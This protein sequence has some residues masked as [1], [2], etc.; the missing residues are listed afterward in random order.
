MFPL[1]VIGYNNNYAKGEKGDKKGELRKTTGTPARTNLNIN[2]ISTPFVNNGDSD[3]DASGNSGFEYPLGSGKTAFF[4][5]GLIWGC[6]LDGVTS[7]DSIRVGG[8]AYRHG[9][10]P[11]KILPDGTPEDINADHVRIYRTRPDYATADLTADAED[12]G[13]SVDQVKKQYEDDWNGW[14]AEDGAPYEDVNENGTYDANVD[15]PGVPGADQTVWYVANDLD[16]DIT[17]FLYGSLP[18]GIEVQFTA[19]AYNRTGALGN[20]LFRKYVFINKNPE[21][22]DF[23]E[24]YVSQWSDPDLGGAGDDLAGCDTTLSLGYIYNGFATDEQY[25]STPAAAGFDFFQGPI[26]DSPGDQATFKGKVIQDKKNLPMTA[27]YFF[28]NGDDIFADPTQGQYVGT[29]EFYRLLRGFISTTG[30]AFVD[31]TTGEATKFTVAG[32]PVVKTGWLDSNPGDRRIGPASGPFTMAYGDTQEVVV[33]QIAAGASEGIDRLSAISLLK[34]YDQQAQALYDNFFEVATPAPA[35]NVTA[36][37][38]DQKIVLHWGSDAGAVSAT[39]SFNDKG[40]TFQG[41]NVYQL[42]TRSAGLE[43]AIRLATYDVNDL[44]G[45]IIGPAFDSEGGTVLD[46]V[47]QFGNDTGIKRSIEITDDAVRSNAPLRNGTPYYFAVTSY[48]YNSDPDVIPNTIENPIAVIEVIPSSSNPGVSVDLTSSIA[49]EQTAGVGD[50]TVT[51]EVV[52]PTQATGHEYQVYFSEKT[53]QRDKDGVWKPTNNN[54]LAKTGDVSLSSIDIAAIYGSTPG[55]VELSCNLTIDGNGA[56]ADGITMTFPEGV[57]IVSAPGFEAGGGSITPVI[58]GNVITMGATDYPLTQDGIFHGGEVWTVVLEAFTPPMS[59]DYHI[60][61]DGWNNDPP[62]PIDAEATVEITEIGYDSEVHQ[63]WNLKDFTTGEV[64]LADQGI[65][66]GSDW[67]WGREGVE[68]TTIGTS[69]GSGTTTIVDG[70]SVSLGTVTFSKPTVILDDGATVNGD[71]LSLWG[72][73]TLF[74]YAD[75]RAYNIYGAPEDQLT[76][77]NED[78]IQDIEFRFTG[79]PDPNAADPNE[80][81]IIEGGSFAT[82]ESRDGANV[83]KVRIPFEVWE[84]ERN[85]Q[86]NVA[87]VSRNADAA[88]PW[89]DGGVPEYYRMSGRDYLNIIAT[90]YNEDFAVD[91]VRTTNAQATWLLFFEQSGSSIWATGDVYVVEF[92]NNL[93]PGLDTYNFT[94]PAAVTY[95]ADKAKEDITEIN[96]F[97]NPYYGT[98]PNEI[99]KYQRFVT[100]NHL[101]SSATIRVFNLAGQLVKTINHS[102]TDQYNRWDLTNESGLPVGSGL[103]ILHIDMPDLGTEKILKVAIIQEQQFLDRF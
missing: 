11:G 25:G 85:R 42:P 48:T 80:A 21:Q 77:T 29:I 92:A 12:V 100:I 99:N 6:V 3:L 10:Q 95:S 40:Y 43:D 13:L 55:T 75:G 50:A 18:I 46:K 16:P 87:I 73:A 59:L 35:P 49:V 98:N 86:I 24:M 41:Y 36:T 74:G 20:M 66:G 54:T 17:T 72:D 30:D 89:G 1:L 34:F 19:W 4:E 64:K 68:N 15:I 45:K 94:A 53:Y 57:T 65:F 79:V 52:D 22:R 69:A 27:F 32:D 14:P 37:A 93:V 61:D 33:A 78:L 28:I 7:D 81:T 88:N 58:E 70:L 96:V 76:V 71:G 8:S 47:L 5:S 2:R 38:L 51:V 90:D 84:V 63:H 39:E 102:G 44:I 82:I 23:R 62:D 83:V 26:V 97:P 9:L 101:P 91:D 67:Y 103:Y 31:P 60:Y 56:W